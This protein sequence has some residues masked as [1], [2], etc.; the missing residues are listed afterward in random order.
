[1]DDDVCDECGCKY[2]E[3][4]YCCCDEYDDSEYEE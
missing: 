2:D 1:M 3:E 4:G